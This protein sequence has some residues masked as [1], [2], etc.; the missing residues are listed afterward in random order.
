MFSTL[1]YFE[2]ILSKVPALCARDA[3]F[4]YVHNTGMQQ[5]ATDLTSAVRIGMDVLEEAAKT[6]VLDIVGAPI[7]GARRAGVRGFFGGLAGSTVG[8]VFKLGSGVLLLL[9]KAT[10]GVNSK[11]TGGVSSRNMPRVSL[12]SP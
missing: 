4:L 9:S 8:G 2:G 12:S 5:K 7:R 10:E 1:S 3:H 11:I 6:G